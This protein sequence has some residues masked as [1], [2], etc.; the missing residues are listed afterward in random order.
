MGKST[1]YP[2]YSNG[3]VSVN[4]NTLASSVKN[5][6]TISANY[7]MPEV[8][9]NIYD[10]AQNSLLSS[11]PNINVFSQDTQNNINSQVEAYKTKALQDLAKTYT[12]MINNLK[13][14]IATRFGNLNNSAFLNNLNAIE[15]NRANAMSDLVQ[16]VEKQRNTLYN[17][18]LLNRYKYLAL[19]MS[20][21]NQIN[22]NALSYINAAGKA[23][24]SG[25]SYN[26]AA[27][28]NSLNNDFSNMINDAAGNLLISTLLSL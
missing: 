25:N 16:D 26:Q 19:L 1:N 24:D 21:Q 28:K 9:K 10:Y 13:N 12:P 14:D 5:G 15:N 4:G 8:E 23:S 7:N 3:T 18:E 11:L 22:N 17:N 20:I 27:Y 6:N 2:S